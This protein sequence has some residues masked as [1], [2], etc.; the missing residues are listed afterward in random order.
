MSRNLRNRLEKLESRRQSAAQEVQTGKL[1]VECF[2]PADQEL[3]L[4]AEV[5]SERLR[6]S[7]NPEDRFGMLQA[8]KEDRQVLVAAAEALDRYQLNKK[9]SQE[10][11][12]LNGK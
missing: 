7:T 12:S 6:K 9:S 2:S 5:V 3:L 8:T 4:K 1:P 11:R 10:V